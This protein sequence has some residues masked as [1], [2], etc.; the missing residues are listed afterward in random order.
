MTLMY[1]RVT[2]IFVVAIS[3][4]LRHTFYAHILV[5]RSFNFSR[6]L[7]TQLMSKVCQKQ[8][9]VVLVAKTISFDL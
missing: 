3:I 8:S 6:N 7:L 9:L 4:G 2:I 5:T 1:Q